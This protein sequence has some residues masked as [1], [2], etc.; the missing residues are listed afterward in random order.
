MHS[1]VKRTLQRVHQ[2]RSNTSGSIVPLFALLLSVLVGV[3]G[4]A[5]DFIRQERVRSRVSQAADAAN[6]AAAR[7]SASAGEVDPSADSAQ[8]IAQAQEIAKNYFFANLAD[9]TSVKIAKLNV[10]LTQDSGLWKSH[11][12]YTA[13]SNTTLSAT[14]G[15]NKITISG[16]SEAS[17]TPGFPVL[18]IA[19]C[20]D[21]TGSMQTSLNAVKNNAMNFYDNLNS[22]LAAKGIQQFPLVR[23]RMLYFKDFGD[24][25]PGIW[26]SDPLV[27]SNFFMLPDEAS[28]F[29]SFV[30]PQVASG[31]ADW[32]ES[33]LECLNA[34]M[35][36][37]WMKVGDQP[38][39]FNTKVTDVY[40]LIV[41]W[42]D[43]STHPLPFTN[44]LANPAYPSASVMPRTYGAFRNKWDSA[45]TI[46]Q[47]HKQILFFG[48]PS[49]DW[50]DGQTGWLEVKTWQSF[51]H[52][53][54]VEEAN[55]SMIEFIASGIAKNVRG[56]RLTN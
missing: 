35:S 39:G 33:G 8:V 46:D 47:T 5:M 43:A 31:G 53:G 3:S 1:R 36:S 37:T 48:D 21:S 15:F 20:V 28:T 14:L 54:T 25:A 44:S 19:M 38:A 23:V 6:L 49:Q 51:T 41:V 2:A 9:L 30:S 4:L 40:P 27:T 16:S 55:T 12:D 45:A 29:N 26:D 17:V 22:A 52:G 50:G 18:D 24:T 42:T 13:T 10:T 11:I 56:L 34:A 7:A 32:A